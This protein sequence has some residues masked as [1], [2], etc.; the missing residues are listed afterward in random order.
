MP[1]LYTSAEAWILAG[2]AHHTVLSY[3]LDA[4]HMRDLCEILGIEFIHIN[5][6]TTIAQLQKELIWNDIVWKLK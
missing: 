3:A 4:E 5:K 2:G 6:D 1:D